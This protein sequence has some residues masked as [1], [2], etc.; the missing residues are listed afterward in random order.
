MSGYVHNQALS[1]QLA[2]NPDIL[3]RKPFSTTEL[4]ERVR[5]LLDR[6]RTSERRPESETPRAKVRP[7][8]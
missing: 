6:R 5:F 7:S 4:C 2:E 1:G 8:R 3:L